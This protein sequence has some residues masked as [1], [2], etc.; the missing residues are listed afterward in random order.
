V[1]GTE[2]WIAAAFFNTAPAAAQPLRAP[3]VSATIIDSGVHLR[4]GPGT[5][6][7]SLGQLADDS[8]VTVLD[9]TGSWY[10]VRSPRGTLGWV[11]ADYAVLDRIASQFLLAD[12]TAA[13]GPA[14]ASPN[15]DVALLAQQFEGAPY[16]W[17]G[18]SVHGFDCSGFTRYLYQQVGVNLPRK[19]G[20][21]YSSR[22]GQRIGPLHALRPGDLVFFARTTAEPGITHAAIYI[23]NGTLIA[24]RSERLGVRYVNLYEPFWHSRYVGGL[25]PPR[26]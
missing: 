21:Q 20:Q 14:A 12:H 18:A 23:G 6:Y 2:G 8:Q 5:Q 26:S 19:A 24:A 10:H 4:T 22:Y 9:R 11:A 13:A 7:A 25:R 1:A 3:E 15:R 17:G 16:I